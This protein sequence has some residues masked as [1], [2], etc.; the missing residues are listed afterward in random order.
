[1]HGPKQCTGR[2][3]K[4]LQSASSWMY[5]PAQ[6]STVHTMFAIIRNVGDQYQLSVPQSQSVRGAKDYVLVLHLGV[7]LM[8]TA[9]SSVC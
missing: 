4:D 6:L 8:S 3:T 1:M 2:Y 9:W 7:A 5:I